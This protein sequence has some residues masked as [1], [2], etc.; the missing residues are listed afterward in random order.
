MKTRPLLHLLVFGATILGCVAC[1][2]LRAQ[3]AAGPQAPVKTPQV[4]RIPTTANPAADAPAIPPEEIIRRFSAEEDEAARAVARYVYRKS[5]RIEE[6]GPDGKAAGLEE[7]V[8]T[9]VISA[10]GVRWQRPAGEPES[11]LRFMNVERD[12]L[13]ALSKIPLFPFGTAQLQKYEIVYQGRQPI[14]ELATYIFRITPRQIEREHAYFDGLIWVDDHDLAIVR[15]YGK[16]IT[17]DGPLKTGT[18]P[19]TMFETYRQPVSNKYW[20]PAYTRSDGSVSSKA[21]SAPVR[22][23]IRWD[24]Y[25]PLPVGR[26]VT[27]PPVTPLS[28]SASPR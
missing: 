16:W 26:S 17:E 9:P 25:A 20:M 10:D 8:V 23:I 11:T 3:D 2:T 1:A 28:P 19:F 24:Q 12:D 18:L 22:L 15:T 27:A 13:D 14:D 7:V 6:L 4:I 5:V 21:G